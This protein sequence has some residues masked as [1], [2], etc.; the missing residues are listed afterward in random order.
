MEKTQEYPKWI[1]NPDGECDPVSLSPSGTVVSSKE[2]ETALLEAR[3]ADK[4]KKS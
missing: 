2:E 3:K 1:P 4:K